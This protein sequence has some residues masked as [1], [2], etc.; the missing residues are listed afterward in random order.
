[1]SKDEME[2]QRIEAELKGT[3]LKVYWHIFKS[4][5]PMGVRELQR[6]LDLS[7][8]SV[9][10]HHLEKLRHLGLLNK[11]EHGR[12]SLNE[13][14]K[15]GILRFFLKV[16]KLLLPRY[17]FYAVFF[18]SVLALYLAQILVMGLIP[19]FIAL[20]VC[21]SAS[22]SSWYEAIKVWRERVFY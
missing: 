4:R 9:A 16:G 13:E 8:P 12:F 22:L 20:V 21:F 1:M 6:S 11:D 2:L 10:L 3:T 19:D 15:V 7:S 14:V 18:T 17:L 5:R